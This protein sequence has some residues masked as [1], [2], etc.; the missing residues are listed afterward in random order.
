MSVRLGYACISVEKRAEGVF[1]SRS[2]TL[3]TLQTKG[4]EE[5]QRL[6]LLNIEDLKTLITYNE[7]HG[8]RFFRITS[9]LFPHMEN[10]LAVA[11]N[12]DFAR[13]KLAEVGALGRKYGHRLTFHPGQ[14]CQLGSPRP[15][16]VEQT[17]RDLTLHANIFHAMGYTP[18]LG[19]VMIVHGGGVYGDRTAALER[20]ANT[21]NNMREDVR[22]FISLEN[23]EFSYSVM[24]L[25]PLC[26]KLKIPL[27][28]D[29]FHHEVGH[30]DLFDIFDPVLIKR[31]MNTWHIRG[32]K[33][34]IHWSNQ[35]EGKR[36]GAHS[37][38]IRNIPKKI[39]DICIEY[40]CDIMLE[41][42]LKDQTVFKMLKKHFKKVVN[43]TRI[44]W[45][46]R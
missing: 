34:K 14:F 37:D 28:V 43:G 11:Y 2:L 42:K 25:L 31:V 23:D 3:K 46:P 13:D 27:C 38:D 7:F 26:E 21:Y 8:I 9:N 39:M 15:S 6:A 35:A 36:R 30:A 32:I 19:S 1:C 44:E 10:P 29:F 24:D 20:W 40:G 4:I 16:V 33:P 41:S 12:I 17:V 5:A 18:T 45:Y 22:Q